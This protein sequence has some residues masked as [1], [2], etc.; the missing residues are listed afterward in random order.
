ML[1]TA[2]PC[3]HTHPPEK[4]AGKF[5][6]DHLPPLHPPEFLRLRNTVTLRAGARPDLPPPA[7]RA[8][9]RP[10]HWL[11]LGRALSEGPLVTLSSARSMA[12]VPCADARRA[13]SGPALYDTCAAAAAATRH[14]FA[15][16]RPG[17]AGGRCQGGGRFAAWRWRRASGLSVLSPP[18]TSPRLMAL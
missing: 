5:H 14:S 8:P 18:G 4:T 15:T 6:R 12:K 1:G 16:I 13:P 2:L 7:P 9:F 17:A 3:S 10:P 11:I